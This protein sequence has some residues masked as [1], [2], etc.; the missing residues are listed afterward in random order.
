MNKQLTNQQLDALLERLRLEIERSDTD[1]VKSYY[2]ASV[3]AF[4]VS[5]PFS[6]NEREYRNMAQS[7]WLAFG[8]AT[9]ASGDNKLQSK[10]I[11]A[12]EKMDLLEEAS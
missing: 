12:M 11:K 6:S 2:K 3:E 7:L 1:Y 5:L 4:P 10:F 9:V 8:Q